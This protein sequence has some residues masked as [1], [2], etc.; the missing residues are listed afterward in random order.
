MG[1]P[2]SKKQWLGLLIGL[3]GVLLVLERNVALDNSNLIAIAMSVIALIGLTAGN[4]YQKRFCSDMDLWRG[5]AIQSGASGIVCFLLLIVFSEYYIQWT[6]S[7]V[8]ALAY[9]AIG[10]SIGALSLLYIMIRNSSVSKVASLFCLVP[11][12]AALVSYI[13]YQEKFSAITIIGV[14]LVMVGIYFTLN[15]KEV[16]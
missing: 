15:Q 8:Y 1:E 12:S 3:A 2:V 14:L 10:V 4:L 7:F 9:M 6:P 5:G 16:T 11:V 13:L